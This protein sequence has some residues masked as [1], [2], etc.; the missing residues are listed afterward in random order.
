MAKIMVQHGRPSRSSQKESV[1]S[2]FGRTFCVK[3]KVLLKHGWDKV[4]NWECLFLNRARVLFLSVYVDDI[5]LAG[6]TE[7][8]RTDLGCTQRECQIS[9]TVD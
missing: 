2:S 5:K 8:H 7:K 3:D 4:L 9:K 6:K 1:R